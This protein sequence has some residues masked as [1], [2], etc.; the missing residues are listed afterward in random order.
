MGEQKPKL[1]SFPILIDEGG[2]VMG[3]Y[4][5]LAAFESTVFPQ[6][7]IVGKDGKVAYVN[8][9]YELDEMTAILEEELR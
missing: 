7:W 8:P 6:D 1:L 4:N 3:R 2:E 5:Q 9:G